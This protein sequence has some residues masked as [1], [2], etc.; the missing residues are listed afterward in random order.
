[1]KWRLAAIM[2]MAT[3]GIWLA[4]H[5]S[6][7]TQEMGARVEQF[8]Q[9]I[10]QQV[11]AHAVR[12][13]LRARLPEDNSPCLVCHANFEEELL[14]TTHLKLGITCAVCHGICSEHADDEGHEI[15][16]DVMF[17]RAE[18][19]PFCE[20][21]HGSHEHPERVAAFLAEWKGK[22]RPNGRE[23]LR[24]AMCTDCHGTHALATVAIAAEA[25][26]RE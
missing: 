22:V 11:T 3:G 26:S 19:A 14:V 16:P 13:G 21:C 12:S 10:Q 8:K 5:G 23:I 18:V 20:K 15:K 17:G 24:Q 7:V 2:V 4:A 6:S 25:R 9:E 1:M